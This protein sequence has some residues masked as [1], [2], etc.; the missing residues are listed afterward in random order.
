MYV[1]IYAYI[2][3]WEHM[4]VHEVHYNIMHYVPCIYVRTGMKHVVMLWSSHVLVSA[5][6]V[7]S[8]LGHTHTHTY[9]E[10]IT[11]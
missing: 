1:G 10:F 6:H 7:L 4:H 3:I 2:T 9:M 8:G 5:K 11:K